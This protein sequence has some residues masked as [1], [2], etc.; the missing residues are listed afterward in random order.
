MTLLTDLRV[1]LLDG[2]VIGGL[3][4]ARMYPQV[5][6]QNVTFPAISYSMAARESVRDIP[7]GPAGR[8][9]PR[10]TINAWALNY[11]Q[12]EALSNAIRLRLDGFKGSMGA[13]D[14]GAIRLDNVFDVFEEEAKAYRILND[15]IISHLEI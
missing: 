4:D 10:I 1:F 13:S 11:A 8:A 9:R 5:L 15:Y 12:S 14:I 6:P 3:I 7:N 2:A